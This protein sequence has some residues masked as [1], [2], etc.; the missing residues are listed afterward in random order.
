MMKKMSP[1]KLVASV[2]PQI[3]KNRSIVTV[4]TLR[5]FL[6]IAWWLPGLA[7]QILSKK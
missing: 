2:I 6:C 7:N 3:E 5:V 4:P 1:E